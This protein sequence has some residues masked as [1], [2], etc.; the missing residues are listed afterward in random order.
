M[1]IQK[2]F[3]TPNMKPYKKDYR[4]LGARGTIQ[5]RMEIIPILTHLKEAC[6]CKGFSK[7]LT[8]ST[9]KLILNVPPYSI[10]SFA[11]L[12][13]TPQNQEQQKRSGVEDV[14]YSITTV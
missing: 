3:Q 9:L 12:T 11:Y 6:M 2:G 1:E 5:E 4:S 7:T 8:I 10:T 13:I 14:I